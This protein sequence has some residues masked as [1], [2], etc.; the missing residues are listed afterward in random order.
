[1]S[2]NVKPSSELLLVSG[3]SVEMPRTR[4]YTWKN[5]IKKVYGW[6]FFAR[7]AILL[8][9]SKCRQNFGQHRTYREM[10]AARAK[11]KM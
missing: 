1:M 2:K 10:L 9:Q 7:R 3:I 5:L 4:K 6:N 8:V 11:K